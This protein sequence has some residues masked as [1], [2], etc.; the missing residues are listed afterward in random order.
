MKYPLPKSA[1]I[2]RTLSDTVDMLVRGEI[3]MDEFRDYVQYEAGLDENDLRYLALHI[4][5][6][7]HGGQVFVVGS[8]L[9]DM[10]LNTSMAGVAW[11]DVKLP[12][13]A[14]YIHLPGSRIYSRLRSE[15]DR[16]DGMFVVQKGQK[17]T[18]C[19]TMGDYVGYDQ[20]G[21][22]FQFY[23]VDMK[24][25]IDDRE[26]SFETVCLP[27]DEN[28]MRESCMDAQVSM[29]RIVVNLCLYLD[30]VDPSFR[31][32]VD[33]HTRRSLERLNASLERATNE[34]TRESIRRTISDVG[35]DYT[36]TVIAEEIEEDYQRYLENTGTGVTPRLHWVR[37]HWKMQSYGRLGAMRKK[38]WIMPYQ[39]GEGDEPVPRKYKM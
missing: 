11:E 17:M 21:P 20:Y 9:Q 6:R 13:E 18:V 31:V 38:I 32:I 4:F 3:N 27:D 29:N 23:N 7:A 2:T 15:E 35:P 10:F 22:G 8:R 33:R 19:A 34:T 5:F 25:E 30:S 12:Y 37:G 36:V 26:V 39:R 16:I 24:R 28:S 1:T 14:F